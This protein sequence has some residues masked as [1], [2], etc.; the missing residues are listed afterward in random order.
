PH[1]RRRRGISAG[2]FKRVDTET[3]AM[4][5]GRMMRFAAI[6]FEFA[7]PM[8]AGAILG[9]YLDLYF[10]TDPWLT[11]VFFLLGVF[12]GFYRLIQELALF[13]RENRES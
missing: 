11:L 7:W 5:T 6:G 3:M 9:H 10:H 1:D 8:I 2:P 12:V 13:Q 4:S